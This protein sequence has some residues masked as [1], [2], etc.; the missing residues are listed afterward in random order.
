MELMDNIKSRQ[1]LRAVE[2]A[3]EEGNLLAEISEGWS[4]V[5]QVVHMRKGLSPLAKQRIE[6]ELPSLRYWY[7]PRT[8]HNP[9]TEGFIS[10]T[11][12]VG[13]SFPEITPL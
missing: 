6:S 2:I 7:S 4:K 12:K 10:D 13:L 11:D 5:R 1:I 9:A 8:P 3:I